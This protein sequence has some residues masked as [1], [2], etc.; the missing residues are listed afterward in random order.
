MTYQVMLFVVCVA[1]SSK[2]LSS[3]S[4]PLTQTVSAKA[5]KK[6]KRKGFVLR[7]VFVKTI[8]FMVFVP[9][10]SALTLLVG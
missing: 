8:N 7:V 9:P 1:A 6:K 3:A 10:F 2:K 4:K 5:K